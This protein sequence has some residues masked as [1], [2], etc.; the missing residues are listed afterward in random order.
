MKICSLDLG[1]AATPTSIGRRMTIIH[2][3]KHDGSLILIVSMHLLCVPHETKRYHERNASKNGFLNKI[4]EVTS[5]FGKSFGFVIPSPLY[6]ST[7]QHAST[8]MASNEEDPVASAARAEV[9][10]NSYKARSGT[11]KQSDSGRSHHLLSS[12]PSVSPH[13]FQF[14]RVSSHPIASIYL[15]LH[16]V[17]G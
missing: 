17:E 7:F 13:C 10:M 5:H 3:E 14:H 15:S 9:E 16:P 11:G 6:R 4:A 2:H 8:E 12:V 1:H